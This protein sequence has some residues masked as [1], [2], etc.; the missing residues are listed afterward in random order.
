MQDVKMNDVVPFSL[1]P[2]GIRTVPNRMIH[3]PFIRH[4]PLGQTA[5][6][7]ICCIS[8]RFIFDRPGSGAPLDQ[9]SEKA[10]APPPHESMRLVSEGGFTP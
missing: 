1:L 10:P 3:Y 7:Y 8:W 5:D 9:N 2:L 6:P 4:A